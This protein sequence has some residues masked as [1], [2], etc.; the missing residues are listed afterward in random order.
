[1]EIVVLHNPT[2]G[3]RQLPQRKLRSLLRRAGY[4]PKFLSLQGSLWKKQQAFAKAELIVVAGGDGSVRKAVLEIHDRGLPFAILPLGTANNICTSL[5]ISGEPRAIIASWRRARARKIDLGIARGP[6]GEKGFIESAGLGLIGRTIAIMSEVGATAEHRPEWRKDRLHR[7]ASVVQALAH[8]LR[9]TRITI[10]GVGAR[11]RTDD[12]LLLEIMN[13]SRVGPG[14]NLAP[15]AD[16]SDGLFDVVS[17]T[18][19][20]RKKLNH[21]LANAVAG[22]RSS[23]AR[24][25][26]AALRL[27]FREGEFRLDDKIVLKLGRD[28]RST[29]AREVT[30]ELLVRPGAAEILGA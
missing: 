19:R 11:A 12:F 1:M 7:D 22:K 8:E 10:A 9:P 5:G 25:K 18:D 2:A 21:A 28:K 4:R 30:V 16:P 14:L 17:A 23:L 20:D 13:I 3:D 24:K 26:T 6:W 15:A 29:R 27:T